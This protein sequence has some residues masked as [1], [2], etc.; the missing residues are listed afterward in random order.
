MPDTR[1]RDTLI[2][3]A[4]GAAVLV[5]IGYAVTYFSRQANASG[6]AEGVILSK[7]FVPQA[8]TEITVGKG[9][10]NSRQVAGEYSFQVRVS[11]E[12]DHQYK[13]LVDPTIYETRQVGDHLLF[14]EPPVVPR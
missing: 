3:V 11:Q 9:G 4:A 8:E 14:K 2:A 6:M 5:F 13:V 10:L 12:N 7:T 1:R